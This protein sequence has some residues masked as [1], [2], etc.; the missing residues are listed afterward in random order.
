M[1]HAAGQG[2]AQGLLDPGT[3]TRHGATAG[4]VMNSSRAPVG[5]INDNPFGVDLVIPFDVALKSGDRQE[6]QRDAQAGYARLIQAL[7]S[8]QGLRI[9]SQPGR[10][11]KGNE[12][13]WVFVGA[14]DSFIDELL[15]REQ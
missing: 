2:Q 6:A 12:E 3:P 11:G 15:E 4:N 7:Q 1:S 13:I 14:S 8:Q 10:G 5:P 9:A